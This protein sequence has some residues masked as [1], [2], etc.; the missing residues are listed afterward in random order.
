MISFYYNN[1]KIKLTDFLSL[2]S[3]QAYHPRPPTH[4]NPYGVKIL[5]ML[6]SFF[7]RIRFHGYSFFFRGKISSSL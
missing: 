3:L 6:I 4:P 7:V 2:K 5:N 1:E